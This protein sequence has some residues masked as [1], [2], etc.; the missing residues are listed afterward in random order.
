MQPPFRL[1]GAELSA[2]S[3][4]LRAYLRYKGLE[5]VWI[6]RTAQNAAEVASHSRLP[7]IPVLVDANGRSMQDSTLMLDKLEQAFPE[8]PALPAD[9]AM[10]FVSQ[11]I[12]DYAD[13]WLNKV[14]IHYR[15]GHETDRLSASE[16]IVAALYPEGDA[17]DA[18]AATI[19]QRMTDRLGGAGATAQTGPV[20]ERSFRRLIDLMDV[21]LAGRDYL[22]GGAPTV[23]DFGLYGQLAQLASDPTPGALLRAHAPRVV[24]WLQRMESPQATGALEALDTMR[25]TLT[26]LLRLEVSGAHLAWMAANAEAVATGGGEVSITIDGDAYAQPPQKYA[27]KAL[28]ELRRKRGVVGDNEALAAILEETGCAAAVQPLKRDERVD[29]GSEPGDAMSDSE[30]A[31]DG[32]AEARTDEP[33]DA[34]AES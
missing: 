15:W 23:A 21:H 26:A 27:S 12:E 22:F 25:S 34:D 24:A 8:P 14:A 29:A 19:V 4:K 13:E 28:Q 2:Y 7:L 18:A 16:R 3:I 32:E 20:L 1:F 11:L 33:A 9:P 31:D 10:A 17:P 6:P 5:H 30:D